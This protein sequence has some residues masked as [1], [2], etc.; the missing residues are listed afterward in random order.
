MLAIEQEA[1]IIVVTEIIPKYS[2]QPVIHE[3]F[4]IDGYEHYTN[5]NTA[6]RKIK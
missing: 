2:K 3:Q 4:K 5:I 1:H 6:G